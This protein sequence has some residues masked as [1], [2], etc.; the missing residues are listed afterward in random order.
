V[1]TNLFTI[2]GVFKDLL[3]L[4]YQLEEEFK[5]ITKIMSLRFFTTKDNQTK[6][7][8]LSLSLI[9]QS[10]N[11]IELKNSRNEK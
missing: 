1:E 2:K 8:H 3:I 5:A 11:E 6:R 10:F 7:K 4:E 9:T